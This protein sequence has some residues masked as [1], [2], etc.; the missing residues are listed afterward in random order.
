MVHQEENRRQSG[1]SS[2][3]VR[4]SIEATLTF[5][6]KGADQDGSAWSN[7]R[8]SSDQSSRTALIV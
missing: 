1:G 3:A 2:S 8:W 5:L 4:A 7:G 6:Q